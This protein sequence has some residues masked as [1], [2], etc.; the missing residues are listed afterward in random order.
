[1]PGMSKPLGRVLIDRDRIA[2]RVRDLGARLTADLLEDL[3]REGHGSD[4]S[5]RVVLIPVLTGAMV[6]AADLIRA[7]PISMQVRAVSVSSYPGKATTSQGVTLRGHF[8][9]DL[10]GTHVVLVDDIHDTGRTLAALQDLAQEQAP[11]SVRTCVLLSKQVPRLAEARVDYLGFEIPPEFVIGYGLDFDG[12]H[13][14]LPDIRVLD[15]PAVE[16]G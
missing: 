15:H 11:A 2:S 13:R 6:F 12:M 14:N 16:E 5:Q 7:M 9:N 1:M 3:Q 10:T 4:A 8:P